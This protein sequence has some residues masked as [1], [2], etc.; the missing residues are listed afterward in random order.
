[1]KETYRIPRPPEISCNGNLVDSGNSKEILSVLGFCTSETQAAQE[2]PEVEPLGLDAIES[3]FLGSYDDDH[4]Y[5]TI[6]PVPAKWR[7]LYLRV[8]AI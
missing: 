1:M 3:T 7:E 8:E 4:I 2:A 6:S 5:Q